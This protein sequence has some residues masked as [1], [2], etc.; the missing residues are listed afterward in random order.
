MLAG[1]LLALL[2]RAGRS[3]AG[4][5]YPYPEVAAG[6]GGLRRWAVWKAAVITP[7]HGNG[8]CMG[9]SEARD[10]PV[11]GDLLRAELSRAIAATGQLPQNG[12]RTG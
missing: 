2:D 8:A 10:L 1:V 4:E 11:A 7:T 6:D 3:F 5:D 9:T 12:H